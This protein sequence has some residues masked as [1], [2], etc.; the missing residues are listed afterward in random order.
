MTLFWSWLLLALIQMAATV[1]PGPA[2]IVGI[3]NAIIYGRNIGI[4]TGIG[5]GLGVATHIIIV[6]TGIA[7]LISQSYIAYNI[8]KYIGAIYLVYIGF[9][10]LNSAYKSFKKPSKENIKITQDNKLNSKT[11]AQG[12]VEGFFTNILNP[13]A[14]LFFSSVFSQFIS[15]ETPV[16]IMIL[17]GMTSVFIETGWYIIVSI[18]L[19]NKF[20]QAKFLSITHWID[21]LFGFLVIFLGIRLAIHNL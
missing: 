5:L 19:T 1:S 2:F 21:T 11:F 15:T 12:L 3:R 8:I 10:C 4:A 14:I 20:I 9:K 18:L 7:F 17:F 16:T 13:K 6:F